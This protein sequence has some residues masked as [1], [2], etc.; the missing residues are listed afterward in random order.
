MLTSV[1]TFV[2]P[3]MKGE[4]KVDALHDMEHFKKMG[5]SQMVFSFQFDLQLDYPNM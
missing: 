1:S 2:V 4:C 3:V 5:W